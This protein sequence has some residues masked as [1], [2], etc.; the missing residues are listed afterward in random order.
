MARPLTDSIPYFPHD[1]D[2]SEDEKVQKVEFKFGLIGYAVYN[3]ILER[4]YKTSGEFELITDDDFRMYAEKWRIENEK[5]REILLFMREQKLFSDDK[6]ISN[7]IKKRIKKIQGER[8]R[9]RNYYK[10]QKV[11]KKVLDGQ[12]IGE[13]PEKKDF[14]RQSKVKESKVKESKDIYI[15]PELSLPLSDENSNGKEQVEFKEVKHPLLIWVEQNASRVLQMKEPLT[16]AECER[17]LKDYPEPAVKKKLLSMHNYK[18]LKDKNFNSNL[19]LR[20]WLDK[21]GVSKNGNGF[22]KEY[23]RDEA[24][25]IDPTLKSFEKNQKTGL[26]Q[27][28][29]NQIPTN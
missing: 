15:E 29:E 24:L 27:K 12:N 5:L 6:L 8:S 10:K 20:N 22:H 28:I 2:M 17:L 9:K 23:T 14:S 16:S 3:K 7:G 1:T 11:T 21:D 4:V 19:T 18:K 26:W 25:K 13:I